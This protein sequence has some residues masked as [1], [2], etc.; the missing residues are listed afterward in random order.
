MKYIESIGTT[1]VQPRDEFTPLDKLPT[2]PHNVI[3]SMPTTWL[4][5]SSGPRKRYTADH[6][7]GSQAQ[8]AKLPGSLSG[9]PIMR[10]FPSPSLLRAVRGGTRLACTLRVAPGRGR[11]SQVRPLVVQITS[12]DLLLMWYSLTAW[13][14]RLSRDRGVL[15]ERSVSIS[16]CIGVG[17]SGTTRIFPSDQADE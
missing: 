11:L 15:L 13:V 16:V 8:P 5:A 7:T 14:A 1:A 2:T 17:A 12:E 3:H 4:G 10:D 9:S 6:P